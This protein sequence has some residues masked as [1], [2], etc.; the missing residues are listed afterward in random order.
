MSA[1]V[2]KLEQ[3]DFRGRII[4]PTKPDKVIIQILGTRSNRNPLNN[5]EDKT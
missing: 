5:P 2:K 3:Y 4:N 1:A